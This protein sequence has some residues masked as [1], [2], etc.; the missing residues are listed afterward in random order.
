MEENRIFLCMYRWTLWP[1]KTFFKGEWRHLHFR[2]CTFFLVLYNIADFRE[3]RQL[4]VELFIQSSKLVLMASKN[5]AEI[6]SRNL[7]D[8]SYQEK[9]V[10][11]LCVVYSLLRSPKTNAVFEMCTSIFAD[12]DFCAQNM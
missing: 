6:S 3:L 8:F 12:L 5:H 7:D 9:A 1:C 11:K 10:V 4:T 2:S